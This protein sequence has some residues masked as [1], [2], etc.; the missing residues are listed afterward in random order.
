MKTPVALI[1]FNRPDCTARVLEAVAKAKPE[2][3]LVAADG[4]RPGKPG[5][6]EKCAS[7]RAVIDGVDWDCEVLTNYSEINLGCKWRP[8]SGINWVFEQVEEA[9]ILE[10]DCLPHQS[11]F[12][13][14]EELLERYRHDER[15]MM[16][17][18]INFLGEWRMPNHS[19]YFS[20]FGGTWGW[21]T[22]QRAW[23]LYDP[24]I[25]AWPQILDGRVLEQL[26]PN[27][28]HYAYW[29]DIFQQT[30]N[31]GLED[32]WDYQWLLA[33][34]IN[35]GYRIFPEVNLVSNIGFRDDA[36]HTFGESPMANMSTRELSFPLKHPPFVVRSVNA[37]NR[38][39]DIFCHEGSSNQLQKGLAARIA[40]RLG[41]LR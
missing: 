16:I 3:L 22:W 26:F 29:R 30:Y 37:D 9:I 12:P 21:A 28:T 40:G 39:Q 1:I 18:G 15:V 13:F 19:Y 10:D 14:C 17:G 33:C 31:S 38:I 23:Q 32:I 24:D 25:K 35:S 27:P 20:Y 4:P 36:T 34:W 2:K 8:V 11:F 5:D 6:V 7:A 41:F